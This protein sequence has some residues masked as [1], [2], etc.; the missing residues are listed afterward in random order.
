MSKGD[1]QREMQH[2]AKLVAKYER[3]Q[4]LRA[5]YATREQMGEEPLPGSY[6]Q[7][8]RA[9]I[10]STNNQLKAMAGSWEEET[11]LP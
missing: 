3:L 10:A 4:G 8:L 11:P 2:R 5:L 1:Y 6:M 9:R 7:K